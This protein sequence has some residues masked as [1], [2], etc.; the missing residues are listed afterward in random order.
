MPLG[1]IGLVQDDLAAQVSHE[2][3]VRGLRPVRELGQHPLGNDVDIVA[4]AV[5]GRIEDP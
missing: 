4:V 5:G 3:L 2:E 1:G